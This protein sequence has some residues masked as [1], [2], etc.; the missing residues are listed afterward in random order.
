MWQLLCQ[1]MGQPELAKDPRFA[2][3]KQRW[4][5]VDELTGILNA[6]TGSTPS[7]R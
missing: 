1:A 6:W 7:M 3:A 5:N 2:N 4:Q